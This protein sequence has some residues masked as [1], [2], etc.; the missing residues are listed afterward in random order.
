MTVSSFSLTASDGVPVV[1][2]AWL[3]ETEP[4]GVILISHGMAEYA[5][6][7]DRFAEEAVSRGFAVYAND[8]RGHGETAGSLSRLGYLADGDGFARVMEDLHE[9]ALEIARRH[10][11]VPIALLGHSFGSFVAQ[12]FIETYGSL[13][14][15]CVLS[16]T[17]GPDPLLATSGYIAASVIALFTGRKKPSPF[18]TQLSFGTYNERISNPQSPSSWLSRD[19]AE[20]EK[21]DASP[22]AGFMCT[23]GFYQ[24]LTRGLTRIHRKKMIDSIPRNLPVF[25]VCGSDDPVGGYAKTVRRLAE[26]YSTSGVKDV[27]LKIYEGARHELLNETNRDEVTADILDWISPCR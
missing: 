24:D 8:H 2:H 18:L 17:K 6:R 20:V 15:S 7:Y 3:P 14:A 9:L 27:A 22:W 5:M 11:N 10:P 4:T 26:R 25:L 12:L 21:Y 23:T 1:V 13:L 16:G 19:V